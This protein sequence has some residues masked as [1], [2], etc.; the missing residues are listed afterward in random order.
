MV[1]SSPAFADMSNKALILYYSRTGKSEQ[2]SKTVQKNLNADIIEIKDLKDRSGTWG[3][4]G[5]VI[6]SVFDRNT[7]IEPENPDMDSY[8][9]IIVVTPIWYWTLSVPIR[10]LF[11]NNLFTGKN[12]I[13]LTTANID[14]KKYEPYGDDAPFM[15]R[16]LRDYLRDKRDLMQNFVASSGAKLT[17]HYHIATEGKSKKEIESE[18]LSIAVK[19]KKRFSF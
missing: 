8:E 6:D 18:A 9:Y 1:F 14:I 3:F 5:A 13:A 17:G 11:K 16:F 10:T 15:K 12:V 19:M 2:V 4:T 7:T